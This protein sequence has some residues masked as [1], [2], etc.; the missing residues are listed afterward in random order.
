M[1]RLDSPQSCG[2]SI[3]HEGHKNVVF[4]A[5]FSPDGGSVA[6]GSM[7]RTIYIWDA[8][9]PSS[10]SGPLK[11]HDKGVNSVSY[12]PTG[13]L[14]ASGSRD[15]SIRLWNTES[16]QQI[17]EP[18]QGHTADVNSV[19]FSKSGKFIASGSSDTSVRLWHI[20]GGSIA[21]SYTGHYGQVNSVGFSPDGTYVIS[22]SD[23]ATIRV[24]D[25]ENGTIASG[26]LRGHARGVMSV[27]YSRDGSQIASG[28]SD[29]TIRLW[30]PRSGQPIAKPYE[31]HT[32]VVCSVAF[33]P[34]Y[35]LASGSYDKTI[36]IWDLRTGSLV[37]NPVQ[38]HDG[39]VYSV[40]FSPSGKRIVS[41][42]NDGKVMIW[43]IIGGDSDMSPESGALVESSESSTK[44]EGPERVSR[45]MT[46]REIFELLLRHGC[47]DLSSQMDCNQESNFA[48]NGGGFGDIWTGN[49]HNGTK[50]AIKVWRA[51]MVEQC[52]DKALKRAAREVYYWSRMNHRHVHKLLGVIIFKGNCLG[53]VSE[54]M[55][56]GNL[57]EYMRKN[58]DL[59]QCEM[60]MSVALGLAY[61]HQCDALNVLVSSEGVTKLADFGLSTI[62][63]VTLG[64]SDTSNSQI[65]STRWAA[66]ELLLEEA[67]K[68]KESDVYALG[69]TMFEIVTGEV[70]YPKCKTDAQIITQMNNGVLPAR[71]KELED[72]NRDYN[73]QNDDLWQGILVSFYRL[74]KPMVVARLGSSGLKV[75]RIILGL[76]TY[77][78]PE[79]EGWV[80]NE[81]EGLKH[82][83]AAYDAGIQ[84]FDTANTYSNGLSEIILGKAI[85][86]FNLPRDEIVVMTKVYFPVAKEQNMSGTALL[87]TDAVLESKG[88]VNQFGLGRKHI[89]DSI[90]RSLERLQLDYVDVLQCHRF[91]YNTPIAE[92]M[93]ALHD[94]VQAGYARYIGM[95]SCYAYQFQAMQNYAIAN[96]LTP[97]ISMQNYYNLIY[98]EEEREMMPALKMFGVGS[99]PWSPLGR[100]RLARPLSQQTNRESKDSW[101]AVS[102][103]QT[104]AENAIINR[105]EALA[106]AKGVSMAQISVAWM[107][108]KDPVAAPIVGT[109]SI[110]NLEDILGGG[111]LKLTE[112][113]IKSLEE[114]YQP[115]SIIGHW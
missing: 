9:K 48:A 28:S 103:T 66:P 1:P 84:T 38:G 63:E 114:P 78:T 115:Q 39:Y 19:A 83:K 65:G 17:G 98:R 29:N 113:E 16:S 80:L 86:K 95:S 35:F 36:R 46:I 51:S 54:W 81:E 58:Q 101:I 71:P 10:N 70:P 43:D 107:L 34:N 100:G 64:F 7:D 60:C 89:F 105:V 37:I 109:T 22:G 68:S 47:T 14:L 99:I 25:A 53:M 57:R 110:K 111:H 31:G 42:S 74:T 44:V 62:A 18:L 20:P 5:A 106:A 91:D 33:A 94:V 96:K 93:Q 50:V 82:I 41:G 52:D 15:R 12:S 72:T 97:F 79:W 40:A 26:P 69:M 61:M 90:K 2:K 87:G 59:D 75:S 55:D 30:D 108:S 6:S 23:D 104:D 13:N 88:Y 112:E 77:G 73:Y 32:G 102:K 4:S 76:M 92:T 45:H 3:I 24:W 21:R 8:H 67:T 11:G 27:D 49:L 56:N 85:K